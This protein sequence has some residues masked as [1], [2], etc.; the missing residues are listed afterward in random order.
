[1]LAI[2]TID[3][4]S[5]LRRLQAL[6]QQLTA[7][8]RHRIALRENNG[9]VDRSAPPYSAAD[10]EHYAR[11]M[12]VT[13]ERIRARVVPSDGLGDA[14]ESLSELVLRAV[15]MV[16][17][18]ELGALGELVSAHSAAADLVYSV[19]AELNRITDQWLR[20]R[21]TASIDREVYR[22]ALREAHAA[23]QALG[24]TSA[25]AGFL[26]SGLNRSTS[27]S[28][29]TA[30]ARTLAALTISISIEPDV[31]MVIVS[32]PFPAKEHAS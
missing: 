19:H 4:A 29:Q 2:M 30:C 25:F 15:R 31:P 7:S 32:W 12:V 18:A 27:P 3:S 17:L 23:T 5:L 8:P 1:M 20:S 6:R 28:F 26:D 9:S 11:S 21:N 22:S 16:V 24:T 13:A 10:A 14:L